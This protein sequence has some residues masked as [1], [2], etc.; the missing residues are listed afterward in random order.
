MQRGKEVDE[1]LHFEQY[2]RSQPAV[3]PQL[4]ES[5]IIPDL[6]N[7]PVNEHEFLRYSVMMRTALLHRAIFT[8]TQGILGSGPCLMKRSDVVAI[9]H[10]CKW[11]VNFRP[12][13]LDFE[14]L[15]TC[16]VYGLMSGSE[17]WPVDIIEE[18]KDYC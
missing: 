14:F 12:K 17:D 13:G 1:F 9:L 7:R 6:Q 5:A 18:K 4:S 10:G 11:R 15:R 16:Y 2:I 3:L 8:T